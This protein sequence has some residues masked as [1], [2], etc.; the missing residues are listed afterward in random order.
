M[1]ICGCI[2]RMTICDISEMK[3]ILDWDIHVRYSG[4][5]NPLRAYDIPGICLGNYLNT[6]V[7]SNIYNK[8]EH[9]F[10]NL[11]KFLSNKNRSDREYDG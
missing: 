9:T 1:H 11:Y 4:N 2:K 6:F 8:I 7:L 3:I 5:R 10:Y